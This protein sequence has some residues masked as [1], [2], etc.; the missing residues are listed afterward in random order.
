MK[1]DT[2]Y[3]LQTRP[4]IKKMHVGTVNPIYFDSDIDDNVE[5]TL[6]DRYSEPAST[7]YLSLLH[8]WEDIVYLSFYTKVEGRYC[9]NKPLLF[10]FNRVY[11]NMKYQREYFE[12]LPFSTGGL[13]GLIKKLKILHLM[14]TG[15]SKWYGKIKNYNKH[16]MRF[17]NYDLNSMD[18]Y[19]L[20]ALL[21]EVIDVFCNYLGKN[22][23]RLLGLAQVCYNL[24]VKKMESFPAS[25]EIIS[26]IL[27]LN[28]SKNMT[29]RSNNELI[30]LANEAN[31]CRDIREIFLSE[32]SEDIYNLL[33]G[34][35]E[36]NN[37]RKRFDEFIIKHSPRCLLSIAAAAIS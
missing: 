35:V 34:S 22:H 33:E 18:I 13:K 10:Y 36:K 5:C 17:S 4:I 21:K 1:C 37:F 16:I 20:E 11:W 31:R 8:K 24:L 7:C 23:F 30:E 3:I 29:I 32:K 9:K 27:E 28:T 6:L 12:D 2:V 26:N 19:Q 25:N 14:L 15:Y